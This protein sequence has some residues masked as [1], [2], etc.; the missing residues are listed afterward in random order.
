MRKPTAESLE[1][2]KY[3]YAFINEYA[4]VHKTTSGHTLKN[5]QT[6][7]ALYLTFLEKEQNITPAK[8]SIDCFSLKYIEGWMKWTKESRGCSAQT[9]NIRLGALRTFMK[10]LSE[11][12]PAY[13][14]AY[15]LACTIPSMK[16]PKRK[17]DG[18][19][20]TAVKQLLEMPK[21]STKTGRRD[22]AF[23]ILLYSTAIRL[24]EALSLKMQDVHLD[25]Q[26]PYISIIGKGH[27][28][29][30]LYLM[31]KVVVHLKKYI[32]EY[33]GKAPEPGSYLFYSR[34]VGTSGKMTQAAID[35]MLKKHAK[36]AHLL[37]AE[38]PIGLHAH[39]F[40]HAKASHWLEEGM[41]I[42]QISFLLGHEQLET[43]MVYLDVT[44]E[45][46]RKALAT[47]E[48]EKDE[49]I[50]PKWKNSDGSLVD[51]CGIR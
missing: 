3:I 35:K 21:L 24:D 20:K 40:R 48:Y 22:L 5:Y 6:S 29:R 15:E 31:P 1:M 27:K 11:R 33:H 28:R 37:C 38:V 16:V 14:S 51:F 44:T 2:A 4:P 13:L 17:I 19:S 7:L 47:L 43:T 9:C 42:V 30:T 18:L 45:D 46:E 10:Y 12:N 32:E 8:L 34:N 49:N 26:K 39:Q 36:A 25:S 50:S 41:N 23:M